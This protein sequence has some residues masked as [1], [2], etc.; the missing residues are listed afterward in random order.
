M[1]SKRTKR[2][3]TAAKKAP[4]RKRR[5]IKRPGPQARRQANAAIAHGRQNYE[6]IKEEARQRRSE[7]SRAGRD[8][9]E[10]PPV[11]NPAR[12]AKA[13][14]SLRVFCETYFPRRFRLA[15]SPNHL[16]FIADVE[17]VVVQGGKLID[18]VERGFGKTSILEVATIWAKVKGHPYVVLMGSQKA[19]ALEMLESIKGELE[20]NDLL[21]ADFPEVCFPIQKLE[22]IANRAAGQLYQGKRTRIGITKEEITLP[23]IEGS[24]ASGAIVRVT[25]VTGRIR[26]RKKR[27][28]RPSLVLIDDAQ[29]DASAKSL[30]QTNKR[31]EII[32]G[33]VLGLA[34]PDKELS[35][36]MAGTVIEK[37]DLTARY[38]DPGKHQ[39]WI[40]RRFKMLPAF[41][42]R[43]ALWEQYW[44]M[45]TDELRNGGD[46][47]E[48]TAFYRD[49]RKIMDEGAE[50][51][52]PQRYKPGEISAI[53]HAL[54][55]FFADPHAFSREYQND[56]TDKELEEQQLVADEILKRVNGLARGMA[57]LKTTRVTGFI[58]VQQKALYWIVCAWA[59]DFTGAVLDYGTW[60]DQ[61]RRYFTLAECQRTIEGE[62]E[63]NHP[64]RTGGGLKAAIA[65][66]L[67]QCEEMLLRRAWA[68]EGGTLTPIG[69]LLIDAGWGEM[70]DTVYAHC[71][72][73]RNSA[74]VMPSIGR[75]VGA[76]SKPWHLYKANADA[77]ERLGLHWLVGT[78][79]GKRA[80]RHASID[81]NYWKSAIR[82]L[83]TTGIGGR[84]ALTLFGQELS[85]RPAD[86]ALLGD[87][88]CSEY[89]VDVEAHGR[90]VREWQWRAERFDN[91]W[92]DGLVGAACAASIE[93]AVLG[94]TE[95]A[96]KPG[97]SNAEKQRRQLQKLRERQGRA[98]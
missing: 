67:K 51:S 81:S 66:A 25:G 59:D 15:W 56:P 90:K 98:A 73:S 26:G 61:G 65:W 3:P 10:M 70:A 95:Y 18:A 50:V 14:A 37:G 69:R 27:L 35:V 21:A 71:R 40:K 12:K 46:G 34:G 96:K 5:P 74:I 86:H 88:L 89:F 84:G 32:D 87:H 38:L 48:A 85:K 60:P 31:E 57:P 6:R 17:R 4:A 22:G 91:H 33:S 29:T 28:A 42:T 41:P 76:K 77:G 13:L 93:G 47:A 8:I 24:P 55:L 82:D 30:T 78:V 75:Y 9:G 68:T 64:P 39:D 80:V 7:V 43:M 44:T 63:A 16:T 36:L 1:K 92:F 79:T 83:L 11:A 58:D 23:T 49:R 19:H 54:N 62:F 94:G 53:Q 2:S 72:G 52:W 45:R 20:E 97:L